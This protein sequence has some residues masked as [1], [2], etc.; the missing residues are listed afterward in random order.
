MKKILLYTGPVQSGKSSRLLSFVQN[1]NDVG[2]I[3]SLVI[4]GKKYLYDIS[5][6]KKK[7]LEADSR[8]KEINIVTVGRYKFKT[9][10]FE[11]GR[12]ILKKASTEKYNYIVID[13]IGSLELEGKGLSPIAD[14]IISKYFTYSPKILLVVRES[15][16]GKFLHHYKLKLEDIQFFKL[17]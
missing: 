3:L 15:L 14:E 9:E 16:V 2:G 17:D 6:G 11:W 1:R 5:S 7:L 13:E 10:V 4:D 8:E 12:S